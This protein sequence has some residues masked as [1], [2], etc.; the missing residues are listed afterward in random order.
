MILLPNPLP[1]ARPSALSPPAPEVHHI[2]EDGGDADHREGDMTRTTG[3][4]SVTI[5]GFDVNGEREVVDVED[6]ALV[7]ITPDEVLCRQGRM[8]EY[9][10]TQPV[11]SATTVSWLIVNGS[12][13]TTFHPRL[14]SSITCSVKVYGSPTLTDNG[15]SDGAFTNRDTAIPIADPGP[16]ILTSNPTFTDPGN[17]GITTMCPAGGSTGAGGSGDLTF[18]GEFLVPPTGVILIVAETLFLAPMAS[19][20]ISVLLQVHTPTPSTP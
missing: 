13:E 7:V 10:N 15:A 16:I 5:H 14:L 1:S 11:T 9:S 6:R 12:L 20:L 2:H 8:W 19:G 3:F 18:V 4:S 17:L